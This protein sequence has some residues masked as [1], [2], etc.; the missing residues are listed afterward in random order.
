M[1]LRSLKST[2]P[3]LPSALNIALVQLKYFDFK[4][5]LQFGDISFN[6]VINKLF[7]LVLV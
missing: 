4:N 2:K 1:L 6:L 7:G 5:M 3:D